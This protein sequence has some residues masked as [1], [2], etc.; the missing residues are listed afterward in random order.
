ML[1][2]ELNLN[3]WRTECEGLAFKIYR[4][5]EVYSENS[6]LHRRLWRHGG[7]TNSLRAPSAARCVALS[8]LGARLLAAFFRRR[9]GLF[10]RLIQQHNSTEPRLRFWQ[11]SVAHLFTRR[12]LP[13]LNRRS[14]PGIARQL[15]PIRFPGIIAGPDSAPP[16]GP[17]KAFILGIHRLDIKDNRNAHRLFPVI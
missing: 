1:S 11:R 4:F 12:L 6:P 15:L 5:L 17:D 2:P 13:S 8:P 14:L 16:G 3:V 7:R 10:S 9:F